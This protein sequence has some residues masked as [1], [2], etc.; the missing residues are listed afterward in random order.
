MTAWDANKFAKEW[1]L[2]EKK[3]ILVKFDKIACFGKLESRIFY[4]F[5]SFDMFTI[6]NKQ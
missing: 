1:F 2:I 4:F 3:T 5:L 6:I